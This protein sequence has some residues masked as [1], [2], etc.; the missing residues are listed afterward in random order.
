MINRIFKITFIQNITF[1]GGLL[2][3]II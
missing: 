1:L 2:I 3:I